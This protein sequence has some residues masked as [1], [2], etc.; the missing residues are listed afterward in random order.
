MTMLSQRR[1][2]RQGQGRGAG[3]LG[4][5]RRANPRP[6]CQMEPGIRGPKSP[7]RI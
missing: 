6:N 7:N 1:Q 2:S 5:V 4:P 3:R